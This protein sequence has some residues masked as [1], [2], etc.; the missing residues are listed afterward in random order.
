MALREDYQARHSRVLE[1]LAKALTA[2]LVEMLDDVPRI[3]RVS[4][5]A[6]TVKSFMKKAEKD[7]RGSPKYVDPINQIQDQVGARIITYYRDDADKVSEI[8]KR[9]FRAI[10]DKDKTPESEWEFGYFGHHFVLFIPNDVIDPDFPKEMTPAVFELQVKTLFQH[11]WS[12][13]DHD[14][15]YKPDDEPFLPDEKR[16]LALAS[17]Q[18]WGADRIFNDLFKKRNLG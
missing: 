10:E 9:Y 18:A 14:L 15:G 6:K 13:A 8:I 3:D 5:R 12:E 1:P 7:E 16:L 2:H 4:A 11:A 17:A